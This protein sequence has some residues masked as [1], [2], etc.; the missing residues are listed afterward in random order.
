MNYG[1]PQDLK[2]QNHDKFSILF[3]LLLI[4]DKY[5]IKGLTDFCEVELSKDLHVDE[6]IQILD[7]A[8][9]VQE[10]KRLRK[11]CVQ[12]IAKNLASLFDTP[13]WKAFIEPN[14]RFLNDILKDKI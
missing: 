10:A 4:G 11:V 5:N 12:F 14:Q 2:V 1:V 13:N 6:V 8:D 3:S 9:K 7:A